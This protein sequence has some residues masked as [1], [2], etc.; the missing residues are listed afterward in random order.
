M[1]RALENEIKQ[2]RQTRRGM[3]FLGLFILLSNFLMLSLLRSALPPLNSIGP[4]GGEG[5]SAVVDY[6]KIN[7]T[8]DDKISAL[9][10]PADG[11][12]GRNG[13]DGKNGTDGIN[14]QSIVGAQG[15]VGLT[16]ETGAPGEPGQPGRTYE[17][18]CVQN[19]VNPR[20]EK[21]PEGTL[22]WQLD[23]YLPI[24]SACP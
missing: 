14:G 22:S 7:A 13:V 3:L 4:Q 8:I 10:K 2:S 6:D 9:P 12:D 1:V 16:G 5:K 19:G 11:K 17:Y 21:R 24:G 18:R 15:P 23:Y 20:M